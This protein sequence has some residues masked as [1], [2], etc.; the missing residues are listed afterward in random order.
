MVGSGKRARSKLA[1]LLQRGNGDEVVVAAVAVVLV[2]EMQRLFAYYPQTLSR[3]HFNQGSMG[4]S[5]LG[6]AILMNF[7][8]EQPMMTDSPHPSIALWILLMLL[9]MVTW[10]LE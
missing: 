8:K 7:E 10:V 3:I 1:K 6:L 9:M 5:F 4:C 2:A